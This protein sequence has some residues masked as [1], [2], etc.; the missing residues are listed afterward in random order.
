[1]HRLSL[2]ILNP[3]NSWSCRLLSC[4]RSLHTLTEAYALLFPV[5]PGGSANRIRGDISVWVPN[6]WLHHSCCYSRVGFPTQIYSSAD[7][8]GTHRSIF[9]FQS[10]YL[11]CLKNIKIHKIHDD[12]SGRT[13]LPCLCCGAYLQLP[14]NRWVMKWIHIKKKL[15][16]ERTTLKINHIYHIANVHSRN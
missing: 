13:L 4:I 2:H 3:F 1:M 11:L 16:A 14:G 5:A 8:P 9:N 6:Q 12:V 10:K 15:V 7:C